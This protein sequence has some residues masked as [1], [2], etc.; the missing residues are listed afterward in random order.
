M[1]TDNMERNSRIIKWVCFGF[2]A[3]FL[4]AAPVGALHSGEWGSVLRNWI[5]I[6]TSPCPLVTDYFQLGGLGSTLLNAGV[7]GM[8]CCAF[9][10]G[11]KVVA[12]SSIL[13]GYFLVIAHCFYGLNF[14]NMWPCF[15]GVLIY[16]RAFRADYRH[17]LH[18]AMF[19]TAFG[20]FISEFLFRYTLGESFSWEMPQV[21]LP[22]V[23]LAVLTGLFIG[24]VIPGLLAGTQSMHKGYSLYNAGLAFGLLGFF[25]YSLLYKTLGI[26]QGET[27]PLKNELYESF[28]T[29]YHQF[30]TPFLAAVFLLCLFC[31]W[32]LN[33]H[34]LQGYGALLA[35]S[36]HRSDFAK[37]YGMPLCL[38]NL[39]IYGLLFLAY[40]NMIMYATDGAGYTGASM[41]VTIAALTF[42]ATGQHPRNVW[43]IVAGYMLLSLLA[44][45]FWSL[46]GQEAAWTLSTQSYLNG[47]AF[48]TG[49]CPISGKFG[50]KA[51]V[52]AGMICAVMCSSTSALHGGL[53]LYNGGLT[54]G[55]TALILVPILEHYLPHKRVQP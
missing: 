9:L 36:G 11:R 6:L 2:S 48:A 46:Q 55:L 17:H 43:P 20:P 22:G 7:C 35:D 54:A 25:M 12:H 13:A 24:F 34:S 3:A 8:A 29:S 31:G 1:S 41:G 15:F 39:G 47:V 4:L 21:T 23:V 51:G 10:A 38:V 42:T 26:P 16:C 33:G 19:S 18:I 45:F 50:W 28:G 5:R 53:V 52:A 37:T 49:L 14:L 30:L 32:L 27:F 40:M 44:G